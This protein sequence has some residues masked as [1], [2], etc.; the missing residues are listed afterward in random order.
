MFRPKPQEVVQARVNKVTYKTPNPLPPHFYNPNCCAV[1]VGSNH[2]GLLVAGV[3]NASISSDN[4]GAQYSYSAEDNS[5][6]VPT[7]QLIFLP[8]I[9][10]TQTY[11]P[12]H[13]QGA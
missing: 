5:W 11:C 8:T 2:V 6:C 4:L 3:F 1:Q 7:P 12:C 13:P 10:D 9:I